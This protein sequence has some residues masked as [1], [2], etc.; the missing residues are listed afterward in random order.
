MRSIDRSIAA[1]FAALLLAALPLG[2]GGQTP[3]DPDQARATLAH[4]TGRLA[5]RPNH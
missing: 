1:R 2:C 4:G 5:R 3:A